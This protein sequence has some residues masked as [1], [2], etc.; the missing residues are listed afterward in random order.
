MDGTVEQ[1]VRRWQ[2]LKGLRINYDT[3]W[4]RIQQL[5]WPF[6]GDFITTRWIGDR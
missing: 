4:Q 3:T 6:A 5:V 1:V 2:R